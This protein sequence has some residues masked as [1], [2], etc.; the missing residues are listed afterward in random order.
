MFVLLVVAVP[1]LDIV[2]ENNTVVDIA[3][4]VEPT[5]VQ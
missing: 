2:V 1:V 3:D 4:T 5:V